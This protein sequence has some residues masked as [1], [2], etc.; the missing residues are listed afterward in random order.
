VE[1]MK[2]IPRGG[3][4]LG[5]ALQSLAM[6]VLFA[7]AN[8]LSFE[9]YWRAD[10]SRSQKFALAPQTRRILREFTEA[11]PLT[12]TVISSPTMFGPAA[13][14][15]GDVQALLAEIRFSGR[16]RVVIEAVDPT[17]N[18]TRMRELQGKFKLANADNL[19]VLEF[20]GRTRILNIARM[21]DFDMGPVA[22]GEPPRL[23]AF[24]GEQALV[25]EMIALV[26]PDARAVYFL[27]GHGEPS[28]EIALFADSL[29]MQ[30]A[31][32]AA[33]SLASLDAIPADAAA[34]VVVSPK[35]DLEVREAAVIGAWLRQS[36]RLLVLLDP[37][38]KTPRLG[39]VLAANGI[40]P[41]DDR[42]LRTV[43]LPSAIGILR[44]VTGEVM[45]T[46]EF[47][48]RLAG[49]TLLFPGAT[50]SLAL[51]MALAK[52][53]TLQL[54][55]LV[56]AAEEFWGE[57]DYAPNRPGGVRYDDGKDAGQPLPI[58][59]QSDR[60]GV[61]D[62]RVEVQT[63]KLIVVG[64]AQFAYDA[65]ATPQGIDFLVAAVNSLIDRSRLTGISAKPVS[66]F[67]LNLTDAQL[68]RIALFSVVLLPA[69]AALAGAVVWWTRRS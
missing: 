28:A 22:Q 38:A 30:N 11:K 9:N 52:K 49:M 53:E 15:L 26:N 24:R 55:P 5:I 45:P 61:E 57:R 23:L 54:R 44:D 35:S 65:G 42:V 56:Q 50:Q 66:H 1:I 39:E 59:A 29:R 46:T 34:L 21:A 25:G 51:D 4:R 20:D 8:L 17:R 63:S 32:V 43:R 27:Q 68:G 69:L 6:L 36:G 14:I 19:I 13:Q 3:I 62:D 2:R 10:F 48:R 18:L 67:A 12:I 7:A 41:R 37:N 60:G 47:T 31:R 58:A 40:V 33:L 64:S 16:E